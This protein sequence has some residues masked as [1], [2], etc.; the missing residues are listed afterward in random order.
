M[1]ST[2]TKDGDTKPS[3]I[4]VLSM[5]FFLLLSILRGH[6]HFANLVGDIQRRLLMRCRC[7]SLRFHPVDCLQIPTS[8]AICKLTLSTERK[9]IRGSVLAYRTLS[10]GCGGG[11][12]G[13]YG[14]SLDLLGVLGDWWLLGSRW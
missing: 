5:M 14:G 8:V 12:N 13:R 4:L 1:R 11:R 10:L 9:A 7:R 6:Q 2:V 3:R